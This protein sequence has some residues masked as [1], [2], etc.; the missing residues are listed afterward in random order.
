MADLRSIASDVARSP[1]EALGDF[2]ARLSTSMASPNAIALLRTAIAEGGRHAEVGR[3]YNTLPHDRVVEDFRI[4]IG[5]LIGSGVIGAENPAEFGQN[6][7]GLL[8]GDLFYQA[9]L[10]TAEPP[11]PALLEMQA[12]QAVS[13]LLKA[14]APAHPLHKEPG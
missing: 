1:E 10:G 11:E 6:F 14:H 5:R 12:R 9:L 8:R 7:I 2:A 3:I 4:L 13:R